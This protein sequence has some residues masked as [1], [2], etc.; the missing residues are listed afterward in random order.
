MEGQD[1]KRRLE[2]SRDERMLFGVAGGLAEYFGVDPTLARIGFVLT[3]L[4]PPTSV[5]SLLAYIVLALI[6]PQEGEEDLGGRDRL[7][8]NVESLGKEVSGL[9]GNVMGRISG[10]SRQSPPSAPVG[11]DLMGVPAHPRSRE[12]PPQRRRTG[13]L[14]RRLHEEPTSSAGGSTSTISRR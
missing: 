4:F 6:L 1:G 2:R 13:R 12:R 5:I 11:D 10:E 7:Q 9:T 8:R 14:R 3:G